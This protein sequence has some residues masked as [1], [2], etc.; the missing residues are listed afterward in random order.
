MADSAF[1]T[2][3]TKYHLNYSDTTSFDIVPNQSEQ[4]YQNHTN[5]SLNR[6]N[7]SLQNLIKEAES[8]L[9]TRL[10]TFDALVDHSSTTSSRLRKTK[11][12]P[13]LDKQLQQKKRYL[14]SQWK[15]AITMK[16]FIETVQITTKEKKLESKIA[17]TIIENNNTTI[18]HH[19]H[20]I[21]HIHHHH[22]HHHH[23]H[24]YFNVIETT[25]QT[26]PSNTQTP[27]P[28]PPKMLRSASSLTSLFR[29]AIDTVG[30]FIP[31]SPP[32]ITDMPQT[33]PTAIITKTTIS[34]TNL[35]KSTLHRTMFLSTILIIRKLNYSSLWIHRGNQMLTRWKSHPQYNPWMHR[36]QLLWYILQLVA[37]KSIK[38]N[39]SIKPFIL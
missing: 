29:Y 2:N 15:L 10:S 33:K 8:S 12:C 38:I 9:N 22:H 14:Y 23:Y 5:D 13:K 36:G 7:Q 35:S 19:H 24:D 25:S 31:Q 11:S 1:L 17:N 28:V 21:H 3:N 6:M 32:S 37:L 34:A 26:L 4:T 30:G 39:I 27:P 18:H 16:Q 20:H